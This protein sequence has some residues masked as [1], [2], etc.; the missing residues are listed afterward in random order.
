M[1]T[2]FQIIFIISTFNNKIG[3][4]DSWCHHLLLPMSTTFL[5]VIFQ[6]AMTIMNNPNN[7]IY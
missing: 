2:D 4:A 7:I 1:I 6:D 3:I 5:F